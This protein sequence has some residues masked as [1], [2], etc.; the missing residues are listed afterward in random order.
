MP[1]HAR[2]AARAFAAS[3]TNGTT[4]SGRMRPA[5]P[6]RSTTC[7]APQNGQRSATV[8]PSNL[9]SAPQSSQWKTF[10]ASSRRR[11]AG[12]VVERVLDGR[13]VGRALDAVL[14]AAQNG[15]LSVPVAASHNRNAPHPSQANFREVT[16]PSGGRVPS[17]GAAANAAPQAMH[18]APGEGGAPQAG[19]VASPS[20]DGHGRRGRRR[21]RP[22]RR[23][24]GAGPAPSL[25]NGS[26]R[27]TARRV[28]PRARTP[29]AE[30]A[31][32][33]GAPTTRASSTAT[34]R[35]TRYR[36]R[37]VMP[38]AADEPRH[39]I[40]LERTRPRVHAQTN[41]ST[42]TSRPAHAR[43]AASAPS[44]AHRTVP[45]RNATG[46]PASTDAVSTARVGS[47]ARTVTA[48]SP[49]TRGR[50]RRRPRRRRGPPRRSTGRARARAGRRRAGPRTRRARTTATRRAGAARCR[51]QA[52][53]G[54]PAP[55]GWRSPRGPPRARTA[56]DVRRRMGLRSP[57]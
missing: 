49:P 25:T 24:D 18:H 11:S 45:T 50:R 27:R 52:S 4:D 12:H 15:H 21:P 55:R 22:A 7:S 14:V 54:A 20:V 28:L 56:R 26:A 19:H 10:G 23:T 6:R 17:F 33:T 46:V 48:R 44:P 3:T 47:S 42:R 53:R 2:N 38:T 37:T 29:S 9:T 30:A 34:T 31:R 1:T 40:H 32:P 43:P 57:G 13:E 5:S 35:R 51:G 36:S 39:G 16:A 41:H 8:A